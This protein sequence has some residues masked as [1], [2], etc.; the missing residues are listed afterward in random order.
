MV[1]ITQRHKSPILTYKYLARYQLLSR[2]TIIIA[3]IDQTLIHRRS[4][5]YNQNKVNH[6]HSLDIPDTYLKNN[7]K[8]QKRQISKEQH[9]VS[10]KTSHPC[11][12]DCCVNSCAGRG[13]LYLLQ[14][15]PEGRKDQNPTESK[16]RG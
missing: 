10:F 16:P 15:T 7:L 1:S 4:A 14:K 8:Q 2:A 13:S 9:H 6:Y 3:N 12:C 11:H 5:I